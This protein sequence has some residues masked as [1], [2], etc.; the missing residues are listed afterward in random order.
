MLLF[1]FCFAL[2]IPH[3]TLLFDQ[4]EPVELMQSLAMFQRE[5]VGDQRADYRQGALLGGI[6]KMLGGNVP[7]MTT[8]FPYVASEMDIDEM[9]EAFEHSKRLVKQRATDG[10][11]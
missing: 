2:G 5:P 8:A 10:T 1:R 11:S 7:A 9:L 6:C 4:L 3:P